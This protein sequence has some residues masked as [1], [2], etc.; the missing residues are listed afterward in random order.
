MI[1]SLTRLSTLTYDA[2]KPKPV[3]VIPEVSFVGYGRI[4]I[5]VKYFPEEKLINGLPVN[6]GDYTVK[7]AVNEGDFY[8]P[9]T[10]DLSDPN[11]CFYN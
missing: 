8:Y 4:Y 1:L 10:G 9:T 5:T 7:I 11:W 6:A 3:T 2:S